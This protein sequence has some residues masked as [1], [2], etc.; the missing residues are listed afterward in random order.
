VIDGLR[1]ALT[2]FTVAPLRPGRVDRATAGTAMAWAPL[3]G[4]ALGAVLAASVEALYALA[5]PLLL[6]GIVAVGLAALLTRGLHL[7]GLADTVDAL[8]SYRSREAALEIMRRPDVGPFGMVALVVVLAAQAAGLAALP[9]RGWLATLAGLAAALATGRLAA[10]WAC[11]RGVPPAR[12]EGLGALV[13]GT[14]TAGPLIANTVAVAAVAAAAVPGRLWQGPIAVGVALAVTLLVTR[15]AV[16]RLGGIT[17]DVLGALVE[18]GATITLLV[19]A[20]G[21]EGAMLG[22]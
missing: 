11:R 15:H 1:L 4:A 12:P 7:D 9:S 8:G 17:G 20:L 13:A 3:I 16:C 18:I 5:A 19:L 22:G 2:T 14:A 6:A 21:T 10:A